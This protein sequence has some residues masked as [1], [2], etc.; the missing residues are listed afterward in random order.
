MRASGF[1]GGPSGAL[2]PL[3]LRG[4]Q[5]HLGR[6]GVQDVPQFNRALQETFAPIVLSQVPKLD[7]ASAARD[8]E[9]PAH[10]CIASRSGRRGG[11]RYPLRR[12]GRSIHRSATAGSAAVWQSGHRQGCW[13]VAKA[14]WSWSWRCLRV[15]GRQEC[16]EVRLGTKGSP[17]SQ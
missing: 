11:R 12:R 8:A 3:R 4:P 14:E 5:A 7:V 9:R 1:I 6:D 15:C 2:R 16:R 17:E 13:R 10:R